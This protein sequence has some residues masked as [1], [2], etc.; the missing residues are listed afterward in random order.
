MDDLDIIALQFFIWLIV[1]CV[2][3]LAVVAYVDH[4][5]SKKPLPKPSNLCNRDYHRSRYL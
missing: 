1:L 3:I 4:R 2:V 5:K